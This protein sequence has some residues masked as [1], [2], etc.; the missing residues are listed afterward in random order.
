M[1][2]QVQDA[3]GKVVKDKN[4]DLYVFEIAV[5]G[6]VNKDGL[7]DSRDSN[8]IK[9][10]RNEVYTLEGAAARAADID[11]KNGIDAKDSKLLLYHRAEVTGYSLDYNG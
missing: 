10:H 2:A 8:L 6:D 3:D 9:A 7:A 11:N 4:G 5:K 1:F